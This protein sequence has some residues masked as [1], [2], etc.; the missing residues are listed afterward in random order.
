MAEPITTR[1]PS[2][3]DRSPWNWLLIVP[4]VLPVIT[5]LFNAET[6]RLGGFPL[7]TW[8]QVVFIILGVTTTTVVYRMTTKRRSPDA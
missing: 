8:I 4:I 7:F 3:S 2:R 6:P 5:P 1:P